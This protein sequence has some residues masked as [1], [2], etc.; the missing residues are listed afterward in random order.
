M[1][2]VYLHWGIIEAATTRLAH[3]IK[4]SKIKF[5]SIYGLPRGGLV[6]AVILSHKLNIPYQKDDIDYGD[7]NILL[8]DDICDTGETLHPYAGYPQIYTVTIHYKKSAMIQPSFWWK[9]VTDNEWI[10]YP[11][12]QANSKTIQDYKNATKGE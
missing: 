3:D 9:E 5:S 10:V 4:D 8:V 12:E 7:G 2:K 6:P 1:K 11:W